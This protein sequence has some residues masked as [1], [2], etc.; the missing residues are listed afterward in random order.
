M[1]LWKSPGFWIRT[2]GLR[3]RANRCQT[4]DKKAAFSAEK[5]AFS[6]QS[7]RSSVGATVFSS[8]HLTPWCAISCHGVES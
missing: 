1:R 6:F 7:V 5:A 2:A 8:D 3:L 4:T